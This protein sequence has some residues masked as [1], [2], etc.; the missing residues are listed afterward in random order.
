MVGFCAA[1]SWVLL[2]GR[3]VRKGVQVRWPGVRGVG[4]QKR[5]SS[6]CKNRAFSGERT[7]GICLRG[8]ADAL[9]RGM[10]GALPDTALSEFHCGGAY[11]CFPL[12]ACG[13]F[14]PTRAWGWPGIWFLFQFLGRL[15]VLFSVA[16]VGNFWS[17]IEFRRGIRLN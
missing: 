2:G 10:A 7:L 8:I 12:W 11:F 5:S 1:S 4:V 14:I 3:S 17:G 15:S 16:I 6:R 9:A 13:R